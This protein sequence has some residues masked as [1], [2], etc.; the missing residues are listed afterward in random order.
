MVP[1]LTLLSSEAADL[2]L[3]D[4]P[5]PS[6]TSPGAAQP[7]DSPKPPTPIPQRSRP[8][9]LL[10]LR[11]HGSRRTAPL[12]LARPEASG[13]SRAVELSRDYPPP[14][15]AALLPSER[16]F[17][18][19]AADLLCLLNRHVYIG[20]VWPLPL[21]WTVG[22]FVCFVLFFFTTTSTVSYATFV[23]ENPRASEWERRLGCEGGVLPGL[24]MA[25]ACAAPRNFTSGFGAAAPYGIGVR[26]G[27][28]A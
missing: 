2:A 27:G 5:S 22:S 13:P 23:T 6:A 15:P 10:H 1:Q 25:A 20:R 3:T 7:A 24:K 19:E 26:L 17:A 28:A 12:V 16:V 11:T 4:I 21:S 14:R 18:G 8:A 9:S